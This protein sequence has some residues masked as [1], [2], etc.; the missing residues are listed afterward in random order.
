[1]TIMEHS[2]TAK[3]ARPDINSNA[4]FASI[5]RWGGAG[6]VGISGLLYLLQG[7]ET[8]DGALRNWIY[9]AL[10]AILV[11]GGLVSRLTLKDAKGAR[12]FFALATAII[13]VQFAQLGG[14]IHEL[15]AI[16]TGSVGSNPGVV[17]ATTTALVGVVTAL[18][19]IPVAYSGFSVLAREEARR[20]TL[21][22]SVLNILLLIPA[23][24]SFFGMAVLIILVAAALIQERRYF[25]AKDSP[26]VFR[27]AEGAAVRAMFLL[28]IAIASTRFALHV[29]VLWGYCALG[30]LFGTA[31]LFSGTWG[32]NRWLGEIAAFA[33]TSAMA[34]SWSA[35]ALD[36]IWTTGLTIPYPFAAFFAPIALI[37]FIGAERSPG[38]ARYYRVGASVLLTVLS[39][40]VLVTDHGV[41][42][43]A[44]MV[45]AGMALAIWGLLRK[46][47]EPLL[48]GGAIATAGFCAAIGAAV[49]HE[50]VNLWVLL[51]GLGV[52][53]VLVSSV[54][55]RYGRRLLRT[56]IDAWADIR[57]WQ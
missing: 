5:L 24:D 32:R 52:V 14:M 51:A 27:T 46:H 4:Q 57:A 41:A 37:L 16:D 7:I 42:T 55:E 25:A 56:T 15:V 45:L 31:L 22:F 9:L 21:V 48:W 50:T 12:L 11:G 53:L 26:P 35:F 6:A 23:R 30:A 13:P 17:T 40:H 36:G 18:L 34:L 20:L 29:E 28:P 38:C 47:R 8:I 19:L 3:T 1:M 39:L 33:G 49:G 2:V 54:V 43:G 44:A 10:M